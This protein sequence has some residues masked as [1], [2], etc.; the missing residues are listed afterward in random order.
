MVQTSRL[1]NVPNNSIRQ[2]AKACNMTETE[3]RRVV[4]SLL[5]A[6]LVELSKPPASKRPERAPV[7]AGGKSRQ[8]PV[9]KQS[10][11]ER[12]IAKIKEV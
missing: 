1:I 2:I 5:N 7:G 9:I 10:V 8:Q 3:I 4:S 12:L 6:G 11:V